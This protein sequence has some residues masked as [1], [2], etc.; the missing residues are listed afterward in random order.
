MERQLNYLIR[1]QLHNK[2]RSYPSKV[3]SDK[4]ADLIAKYLVCHAQDR[5]ILHGITQAQI[6]YNYIIRI[7]YVFIDNQQ[8]NL[9]FSRN[10]IRTFNRPHRL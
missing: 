9:S 5:R 7:L 6:A 2:N 8:R 10:M 1:E 3:L 4:L